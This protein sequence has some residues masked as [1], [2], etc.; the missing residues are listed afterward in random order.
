MSLA[1]LA[2]GNEASGVNTSLRAFFSSRHLLALVL[3]CVFEIFVLYLLYINEG[4]ARYLGLPQ[5]MCRHMHGVGPLCYLTHSAVQ[6]VLSLLAASVLIMVYAGQLFTASVDAALK[7]RPAS[8]LWFVQFFAFFLLLILPASIF[9]DVEWVSVVGGYAMLVGSVVITATSLLLIWSWDSLRLALRHR[10]VWFLFG[11][12]CI[13]PLVSFFEGWTWNF[14]PA[15]NLTFFAV[16]SSLATVG[17]EVSADV[18]TKMI[19]VEDFAVLVGYHC[20]GLQGMFLTLAFQLL[21]FALMAERFLFG[22]YALLIFVA[23]LC[24]FALNTLRIIVLML[25]GVHV[26]EELAV[27]GFHSYAGWILFLVLN[28]AVVF[29]AERT[30]WF[31]GNANRPTVNRSSLRDD[32][33]AAKI[34]PF[35]VFMASAVFV[36][37]FFTEAVLAYPLRVLVALACLLFFLPAYRWP[38]ISACWPGVVVGLGIGLLWVGFYIDAP[39]TVSP[40]LESLSAPLLFTWVAFRLLGTVFVAP[41][42]EELFFRG[43]L[44]SRLNNGSVVGAAIALLISSAAFAVLHDKWQL[45][46]VA[47]LCFGGLYMLRKRLYEVVIAHALANLLIAI[48]ALTTGNWSLI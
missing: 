12:V 21:Y 40:A 26:S 16:S 9:L 22:R 3:L 43:Y 28:L 33:L 25:L 32:A 34:F 23:V 10:A 31:S 41:L 6:I 8:F 42:V 46:F 14:K 37:A 44:L 45:A 15:T 36:G 1:G 39:D 2:K 27:N 38:K 18:S 30:A 19:M 47:G 11:A 35:V 48:V 24:S 5:D 20:S 29:I 4:F 13:T 17:Y 7:H